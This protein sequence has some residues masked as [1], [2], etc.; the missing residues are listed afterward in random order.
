MTRAAAIGVA[1]GLMASGSAPLTALPS[2]TPAM[3]AITVD[4]DADGHLDVATVVESGVAVALND[5]AAV[6]TRPS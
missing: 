5:G 2:A 6:F 3:T 1:C 4:L